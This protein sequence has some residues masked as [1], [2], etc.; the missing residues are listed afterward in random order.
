METI[1]WHSRL[2]LRLIKN[3]RDATIK[4]YYRITEGYKY[5]EHPLNANQNVHGETTGS[6]VAEKKT[7]GIQ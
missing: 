5:I 7:R 4:D 1:D 2:I 3:N 6:T